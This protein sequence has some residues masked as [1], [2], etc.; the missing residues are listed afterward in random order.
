MII[1]CVTLNPMKNKSFITLLSL[2]CF[3]LSAC[4]EKSDIIYSDFLNFDS[5]GMV[6]NYEYLFKPEIYNDSIHRNS[7]SS[8][9]YALSLIVRYNETCPLKYLPLKIEYGDLETDSVTLKKVEIPLFDNEDKN[10]G[11]GNFGLYQSEISINDNFFLKEGTFLS[12]ATDE[13]DTHGISALGII[14]KRLQ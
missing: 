2:M 8:S 9:P 5:K 1:E 7:F 12:V 13:K 4:R 14:I 6:V 11:K 10:T 3:F